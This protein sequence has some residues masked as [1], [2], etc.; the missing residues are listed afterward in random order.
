MLEVV[1]KTLV[2]VSLQVSEGESRN[3][4]EKF[5]RIFHLAAS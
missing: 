2:A 3:F 1:E 5:F 4:F